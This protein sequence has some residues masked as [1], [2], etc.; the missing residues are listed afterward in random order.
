MKFIYFLIMN[1]D[2]SLNI[3]KKKKKTDSGPGSWFGK[4]NTDSKYGPKPEKR[5]KKKE[6][7]L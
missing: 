3:K 1:R 5:K 7:C 6:I 4:R 2:L